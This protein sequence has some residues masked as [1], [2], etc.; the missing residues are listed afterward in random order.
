MRTYLTASVHVISSFV[1]V[2]IVMKIQTGKFFLS[3]HRFIIDDD[4]GT[5]LN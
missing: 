4:H 1:L 2:F 5:E 3:N